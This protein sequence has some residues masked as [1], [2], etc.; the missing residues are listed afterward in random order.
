MPSL[1]VKIPPALDKKLRSAA[2]KRRE[3]LSTFARRALEKEVTASAPD[4]AALAAGYKGMFR[5]PR[6]LS[7]REGYGR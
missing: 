1:T 5:G 3:P 7:E 4:F 6:D 2:L